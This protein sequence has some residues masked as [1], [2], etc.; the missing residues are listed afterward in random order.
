MWQ[1]GAVMEVAIGNN[2]RVGSDRGA[3]RRELHASADRPR[4]GRRGGTMRKSRLLSR[5]PLCLARGRRASCGTAVCDRI[6]PESFARARPL[7]KAFGRRWWAM[8]IC[9][10]AFGST[11]GETHER[12]AGRRPAGDGIG[13]EV[14]A[15]VIAVLEARA[16]QDGLVLGLREAAIGGADYESL[17]DPLP[18][19]TLA[20]VGEAE[21]V[22]F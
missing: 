14:M 5:L 1:G 4:R 17:G 8:S 18:K 13:R 19:A 20:A 9:C 2:L 21:A 22:L 7:P 10:W 11:P 3:G 12:A 6:G 15:E 16:R